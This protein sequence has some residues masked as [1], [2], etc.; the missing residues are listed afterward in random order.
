MPV[1]IRH[2]EPAAEH[3]MSCEDVR[4]CAAGLLKGH[5]WG[6][7]ALVLLVHWECAKQS[8]T[9]CMFPSGGTLQSHDVTTRAIL[10]AKGHCAAHLSMLKA[11]SIFWPTPAVFSSVFVYAAFAAGLSPVQAGFQSDHAKTS[12][13]KSDSLHIMKNGLLNC[14]TH[15]P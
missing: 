11:R 10:R 14:A 1:L 9:P 6:P 7:A 2:V 13:P 8:H 3:E 15:V 12:L 4:P 5:V